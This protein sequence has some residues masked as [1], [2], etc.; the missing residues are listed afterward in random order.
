[1]IRIIST[2]RYLSEFSSKYKVTQIIPE[3]SNLTSTKISSSIYIRYGGDKY[4]DD[5]YLNL[6]TFVIIEENNGYITLKEY[7][8]NYK[9]D[10]KIN[11]DTTQIYR[12]PV[13]EIGNTL[14]FVQ[15]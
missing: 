11:R 9:L 14:N 12:V 13:N 6:I 1:M 5:P 8:D 4:S 15:L 10:K 3:I 2:D 7:T